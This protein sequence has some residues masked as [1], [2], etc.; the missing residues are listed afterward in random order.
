MQYPNTQTNTMIGGFIPAAAFPIQGD[1][2]QPISD[3]QYRQMGFVEQF[4][5]IPDGQL[6]YYNQNEDDK[7]L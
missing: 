7:V 1:H 5:A 2:V 6:S 4:P 3:Q